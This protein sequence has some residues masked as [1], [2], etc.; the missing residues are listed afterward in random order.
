MKKLISI[1]FLFT[2]TLWAGDLFQVLLQKLDMKEGEILVVVYYQPATCVKCYLEPQNYLD[3]INRYT[4]SNRVKIVGMIRCDRDIEMKVFK[5]EINW[6]YA[7]HRDNG[8][9][10][11]SLN[12]PSDAIISLISYDR[13]RKLHIIR[14][15]DYNETTK[16]ILVFFK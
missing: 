1:F 2:A 3:F 9:A 13:N 11:H 7:M 14:S 15:S 4:D 8:K 16:K 12:A 5:R 10:R 6:E